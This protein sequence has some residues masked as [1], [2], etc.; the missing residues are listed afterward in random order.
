VFPGWWSAT[1]RPLRKARELDD[2]GSEFMRDWRGSY[3]RLHAR[4]LAAARDPANRFVWLHLNVPHPPG[5]LN[6]GSRHE[7]LADYRSNLQAAA[8]LIEQLVQTIQAGG[9]PA[10][11][12]LVSDHWL[13]EKEFWRN[14]YER[15]RSPGLGRAGKAD[16]QR[17]PYIVWFSDAQPGSGLVDAEPRSTTTVRALSMAL[18]RGDVRSPEQARALLAGLPQDTRPIPPSD[19]TRV[20]AGDGHHD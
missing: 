11:L 9:E 4:A 5:V 20:H 15:H 19:R 13:R 1:N 16:D 17:V 10:T 14:V 8:G 12:V 3:L 18:V 7:L 6:E 2:E